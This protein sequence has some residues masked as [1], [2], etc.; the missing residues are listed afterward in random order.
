MAEKFPDS[1]P[2]K[3]AYEHFE[4]YIQRAK[5][6]IAAGLLLVR[7][8]VALSIVDVLPES[9]P[10][11]NIPAKTSFRESMEYRGFL[12]EYLEASEEHITYKQ[13]KGVSNDGFFEV[14]T[15]D[16]GEKEINRGM[17]SSCDHLPIYGPLDLHGMPEDKINKWQQESIK[18][19][20]YMSSAPKD[21]S[22]IDP[23]NP[24]VTRLELVRLEIET[25]AYKLSDPKYAL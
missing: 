15:I 9:F 13:Y 2:G 24:S 16:Q 1:E 7:N 14:R 23:N 5:S 11:V 3:S 17:M 19:L 10:L 12:Y 6:A 25:P 8:E 4:P 22:E 18:F 20:E 21:I